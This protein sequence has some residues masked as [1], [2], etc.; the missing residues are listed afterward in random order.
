[1]VTTLHA[2]SGREVR[3]VDPEREIDP[4]HETRMVPHCAASA[5]ADVHMLGWQDMADRE[6]VL[7]LASSL[8]QRQGAA[9]LAANRHL[10]FVALQRMM[11][12]AG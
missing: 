7:F 6:N 12:N 3:I 5:L 8:G 1:M 9:W 10:Y 11:D 4:F 2:P